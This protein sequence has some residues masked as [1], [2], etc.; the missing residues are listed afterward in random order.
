MQ[1]SFLR[2]PSF[3]LDRSLRVQLLLLAAAGR[4]VPDEGRVAGDPGRC[5][6]VR[7]SPQEP[8]PPP[9]VNPP[10]PFSTRLTAGVPSTL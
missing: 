1:L 10:Q 2:G 6:L 7:A 9:H 5:K 4:T 8:T 3:F